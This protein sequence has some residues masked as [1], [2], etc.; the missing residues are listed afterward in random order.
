MKANQ[1]ASFSRKEERRQFRRFPMCLFAEVRRDDLPGDVADTVRGHPQRAVRLEVR[2]LSLGGLHCASDVALS[3]GAAV[4]LSLP[5]LASRP[6]LTISGRVVRC[7][8]EAER[9]DVGIE[10]CQNSDSLKSSPWLR[11]PELFYL[12][13]IQKSPV[14]RSVQEVGLRQC[15]HKNGRQTAVAARRSTAKRSNRARVQFVLQP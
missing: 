8:F 14:R 6:M 2:D 4:T 13:S 3:C 11:V 5:S 9:F 15:G 12:A 7:D 10:F 1:H